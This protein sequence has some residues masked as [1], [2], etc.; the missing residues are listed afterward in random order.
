MQLSNPSRR[1]SLPAPSGAL[2]AAGG[3]CG[4]ARRRESV[5][6][7][8]AAQKPTGRPSKS[9]PLPHRQRVQLLH[10]RV[11]YGQHKPRH[12][13]Q[14]AHN[15]CNARVS[16]VRGP[17]VLSRVGVVLLAELVGLCL[18]DGFDLWARPK[19][20]GIG[21]S[22]VRGGACIIERTHE[23]RETSRTSHAPHAVVMWAGVRG[24]SARA[25]LCDSPSK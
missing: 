1:L 15:T 16:Y 8:A 6:L 3:D 7:A 9:S 24:R 18:H 19:F 13:P 2:C 4:R 17:L 21:R 5:P 11:A 22:F 14:C 25:R 23:P 12:T 20:C 10:R